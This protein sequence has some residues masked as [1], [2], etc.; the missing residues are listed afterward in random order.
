MS[1]DLYG[2]ASESRKASHRMGSLKDWYERGRHYRRCGAP[3]LS[4]HQ[5]KEILKLAPA[6]VNDLEAVQRG[7]RLEDEHLSRRTTAIWG[8]RTKDGVGRDMRGGGWGPNDGEEGVQAVGTM[9]ENSTER[10]EDD[11]D[12]EHEEH[13]WII[14][15]SGEDEVTIA[16]VGVRVRPMYGSRKTRVKDIQQEDDKAGGEL[17]VMRAS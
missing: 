10:G 13:Y 15:E 1:G 7:M 11:M 3:V 9:T 6:S 8:D 16:L 17:E 2:V 14:R 5:I 4:I 12:A